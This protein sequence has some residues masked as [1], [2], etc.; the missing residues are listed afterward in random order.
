VRF[1]RAE[2]S[3]SASAAHGI[4]GEELRRRALTLE[5]TDRDNFE[6][7]TQMRCEQ[8]HL[9]TVLRRAVVV[10]SHRYSVREAGNA[11]RPQPRKAIVKIAEAVAEEDRG[12][13]APKLVR[14]Y[15]SHAARKVRVG[16]CV[17]SIA[18]P[19]GDAQLYE[20]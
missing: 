3:N 19:N 7:H 15:G 10:Q 8:P 1:L 5:N 16:S 18:G 4:L 17:T 13:I 11:K 9:K 2:R 12:I 20:R 14:G 6:R